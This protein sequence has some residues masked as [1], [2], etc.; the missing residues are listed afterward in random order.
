MTRTTPRSAPGPLRPF[1]CRPRAAAVLALALLGLTVACTSSPSPD[2]VAG[3]PTLPPAQLTELDSGA[4]ASLDRFGETPVVLNLW[5]P[6]CTPCRTEMPALQ[7]AQDRFAG[8]IQVVGMTDDA[9]H[10]AA[11][12][13]AATAG[14]TYPLLVD[15]DGGLQA[16]LG[17]TSLPATVFLDREG[18]VL[19]LHAGALDTTTLDD[20]IGRLYAIA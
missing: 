13:A 7:A 19:E 20:L 11:M 10:D 14:V 4:V 2:S 9:D 8:R 1:R 15:V 16:D 5:A 17:V 12:E 18:R 3:P 6:W